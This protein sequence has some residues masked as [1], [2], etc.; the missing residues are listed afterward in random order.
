MSSRTETKELCSVLFPEVE[1]TVL[2]SWSSLVC[3][4]QCPQKKNRS[5]LARAEPLPSHLM[6]V[7][8]NESL[9]FPGTEVPSLP[10]IQSSVLSNEQR[11]S[12]AY[13][14]LVSWGSSGP[15]K[16]WPEYKKG[17]PWVP[18]WTKSSSSDF[19]NY[20]QRDAGKRPVQLTINQ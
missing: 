3:G 5:A 18:D 6:Q 14:L 1:T 4:L 12:G 15:P 8:I 16:K 7:R 20:L 17:A 10:C 19:K 11:W 2:W 9:Q 13:L